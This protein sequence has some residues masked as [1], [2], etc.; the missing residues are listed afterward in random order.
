[1][2]DGVLVA[3]D[4]DLAV[5]RGDLGGDRAADLP[6]MLILGS[7][8]QNKVFGV[9]DRD[10]CFDHSSVAA[11]HWRPLNA[12]LV[13]VAGVASGARRRREGNNILS[14][15]GPRPESLSASRTAKYTRSA[16]ATRG[17]RLDRLTIRRNGL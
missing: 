14:P 3:L 1:M 10:G 15:G 4:D 13:S 2:D 6:E 11:A 12:S 7:Q 17:S 8:Q 5:A 9:A 16:E